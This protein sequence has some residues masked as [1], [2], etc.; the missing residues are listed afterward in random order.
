MPQ[1]AKAAIHSY[2]TGWAGIGFFVVSLLAYGP[3]DAWLESIVPGP[4]AKALQGFFAILGVAL[5]WC[6]KGPFSART[7]GSV[8]QPP[9][10]NISG[11]IA[12]GAINMPKLAGQIAAAL[13]KAAEANPQAVIAVINSIEG[14]IEG[15][16]NAWVESVNLSP[17]DGA[18]L[19]VVF[20]TLKPLFVAELQKIE[21]ENSGAVI[22]AILDAEAH[23]LEAKLGG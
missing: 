13:I 8:Q 18:I 5:T 9:L 23:A 22:F 3:F 19:P 1:S 12:A 4:V 7:P 15:R 16:I 21:A 20:N 10:T 11:L 17:N 14:G 2:T 6:G